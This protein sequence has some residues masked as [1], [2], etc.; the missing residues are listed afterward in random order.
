[1]SWNNA[2]FKKVLGLSLMLSAWGLSAAVSSRRFPLSSTASLGAQRGSRSSSSFESG[3]VFDRALLA[4]LVEIQGAP[5]LLTD[6]NG[7]LFERSLVK[8]T[9]RTPRLVVRRISVDEVGQ[10]QNIVGTRGTVRDLTDFFLKNFNK[11]KGEAFNTVARYLGFQNLLDPLSGNLRVAVKGGALPPG[12]TIGKPEYAKYPP[13][14]VNKAAV[15][16]VLNML[17]SFPLPVNVGAVAMTARGTLEM[18]LRDV[19]ST[20][21]LARLVSDNPYDCDKTGTVRADWFV[22]K[23]MDPA[24][25]YQTAGVDQNLD[26]FYAQVGWTDDKFAFTRNK[27]L[28]AGTSDGPESLP[29]QADQRVLE[30]QVRRNQT[31]RVCF[32]SHDFSVNQASGAEGEARDVTLQGPNFTADGGEVICQK[33]NGISVYGLHDEKNRVLVNTAPADVALDFGKRLSSPESCLKCHWNGFHGGGRRDLG[34]GKP[35]TDHLSSISF[36]KEFFGSNAEYNSV[37]RNA[38][39]LQK[40]AIETIGSALQNP[41]EPKGQY[42]PVVP[43]LAEEYRK[44]LTAER[45]AQELGISTER[46]RQFIADSTSPRPAGLPTSITRK[47]FERLYCDARKKL[48]GAKFGDA[49]LKPAPEPPA[50]GI[51]AS[52]HGTAAVTSG[53]PPAL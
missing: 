19:L 45:V 8:D 33:S 3:E 20:A 32:R 10:P 35:Y 34:K 26:K 7:A 1:M 29:G 44:P 37:A 22:T 31:N 36:G 49:Q 18:N 46:A 39:A 4:R 16:F 6:G 30:W 52:G 14:V 43:D 47:Q 13:E 40:A 24:I 28:V 53:R 41:K 27:V 38:S 42:L 2:T 15:S 25:Y 50:P 17:S 11:F 48:G 12:V 5:N 21:G 9:G 23:A 51:P